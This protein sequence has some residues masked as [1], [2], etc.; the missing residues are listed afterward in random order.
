MPSTR[1]AVCGQTSRLLLDLSCGRLLSSALLSALL[2][3]PLPPLLPPL[4]LL[5][6]DLRRYQYLPT[7]PKESLS[8]E[9]DVQQVVCCRYAEG[10][11]MYDS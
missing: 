2:P 10:Q 3:P 1:E 9:V 6:S 8:S 11:S 7:K 4:V 5:Q